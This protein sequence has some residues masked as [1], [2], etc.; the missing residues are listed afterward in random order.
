ML[1][2]T[3]I[4]LAIA[5]LASSASADRMYAVDTSTDSLYVFDSVSG[6]TLDLVGPLNPDP[7]RY[8]TPVSMAVDS[9]GRIFVINNSPAGDDGLSRV[10]PAT[11]L[12]SNI[13]GDVGGSISFGPG[14]RLFGIDPAGTLAAVD[15]S[16]GLPPRWAAHRC[17]GSSG[18]TS[19]AATETSTASPARAPAQRPSCYGSIRPRE[20]C[21]PTSRSVPA[22][23][24]VPRARSPSSATANSS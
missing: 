4:V 19:T 6:L 5:G 20:T 15:T 2:T 3:L 11:G 10:D 16:T 23:S 7:A 18:S 13:G 17:L 12:A 1:R 21:W 9:R 8:S 14:G 24:A 22:S